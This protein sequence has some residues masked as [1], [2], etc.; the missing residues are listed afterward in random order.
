LISRDIP[1]LREVAGDGAYYFKTTEPEALALAV[2]EWIELFS[3]GAQPDSGI[4]GWL[5]WSQSAK[6]LVAKLFD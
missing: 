4:I 5:S 3:N 1:V 2:E 6:N